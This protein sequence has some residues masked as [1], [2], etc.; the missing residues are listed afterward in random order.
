[1]NFP[2]FSSKRLREKESLPTLSEENEES[3]AGLRDRVFPC[4]A[5]TQRAGGVRNARV[6]E[7][8]DQVLVPE[9]HHAEGPAQR[10]NAPAKPEQL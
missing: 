7:P 3:R 5:A 6:S 9:S 2:K 4:E 8:L 1:M 10:R